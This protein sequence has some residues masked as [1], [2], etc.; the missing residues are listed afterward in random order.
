MH[1]YICVLQNSGEGSTRNYFGF[2]RQTPRANTSGDSTRGATQSS[3]GDAVGIGS[4]Q[5]H[6]GRTGSTLGMTF[7]S[8]NAVDFNVVVRLVLEKYVYLYEMKILFSRKHF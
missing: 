2:G 5:G 8:K 6:A 7:L 3:S 1:F 4:G